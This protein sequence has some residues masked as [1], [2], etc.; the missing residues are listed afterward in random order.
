VGEL[1]FEL[2]HPRSRGPDLWE[3]LL[4]TGGDLGIMPH[5]LDALELLRLE[6]GHVYLGQDTLPDD[7]PA[8]LGLGWAVRGADTPWFVGRPA[9]GRLA[10]LPPTR[11]LAGLAFEDAPEDASALRGQPLTVDGV[12]S[13]RITSAERSDALGSAIG[14]GWIRAVDGVFPDRLRAGQTLARVVPTP[15]YDPEGVRLRA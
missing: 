8:K 13:G 7:T 11:R 6:K 10:G 5:G 9:L 15:F 12:V 3:A 4:R 1:A 2:H 14:L